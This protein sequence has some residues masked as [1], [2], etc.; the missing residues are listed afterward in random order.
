MEFAR[1]V[2]IVLRHFYEMLKPRLW[3][4]RVCVLLNGNVDYQWTFPV[5]DM[6]RHCT[7]FAGPMI[8]SIV[9]CESCCLWRKYFV[10]EYSFMMPGQSNNI[11]WNVRGAA[12]TDCNLL[13][14]QK[15]PVKWYGFSNRCIYMSSKN[16][17]CFRQDC[18][19]VVITGRHI[20]YSLTSVLVI[21]QVVSIWWASNFLKSRECSQK[22]VSKSCCV[23]IT[24]H[25]QGR[26]LWWIKAP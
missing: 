10:S 1:C 16:L 15:D 12:G 2:D 24:V 6:T 22:F 5:T 7:W 26:Q 23:H 20:L 18:L 25:V 21:S 8:Y 19:R 14:D 17:S 13:S 4:S 3:F 11:C 9:H